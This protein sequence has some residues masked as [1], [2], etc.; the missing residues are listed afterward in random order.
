MFGVL[1]SVSEPN[2]EADR[3]VRIAN[4]FPNGPNREKR[5]IEFCLFNDAVS[6][7]DDIQ[8]ENRII[9]NNEILKMLDEG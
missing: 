6:G 1:K 7:C 9:A 8:S 5:R 2:G 4:R 3:R